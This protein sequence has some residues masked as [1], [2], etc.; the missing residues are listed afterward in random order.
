VASVRQ[1]YL[2]LGIPELY[3]A[4]EA[5]VTAKGEALRALVGQRVP[6]VAAALKLL[7]DKTRRVGALLEKHPLFHQPSVRE[8]PPGEHAATAIV[9]P[10]RQVYRGSAREEASMRKAPSVIEFVSPMQWRC[11]KPPAVLA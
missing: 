4:Y 5:E 6:E 3:L 11:A 9:P 7:W 2:E 10:C 1:L 8:A